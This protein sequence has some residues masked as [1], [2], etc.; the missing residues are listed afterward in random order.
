MINSNG[1]RVFKV[2]NLM[3]ADGGSGAEVRSLNQLHLCLFVFL[4]C[5]C[6]ALLCSV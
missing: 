5:S 4:P 2:Y 1:V 6:R 3:S